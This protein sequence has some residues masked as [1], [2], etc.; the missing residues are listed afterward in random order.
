[1]AERERPS[2]VPH[3]PSKKPVRPQNPGAASRKH[4]KSTTLLHNQKQTL[5]LL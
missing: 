5:Y 4:T 2:R 3:E 1:M